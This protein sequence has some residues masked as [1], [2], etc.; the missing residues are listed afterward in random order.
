MFSKM[1]KIKKQSK[2]YFRQCKLCEA[3]DSAA[4]DEPSLML[5]PNCSCN[6]P[7]PS[8]IH[9][10][11]LVDHMTKTGLIRCECDQIYQGV[12]FTYQPKSISQYLATDRASVLKV[13]C[14]IS[15]ALLSFGFLARSIG[16]MVSQTCHQAKDDERK[17]PS[18][19][20]L[21]S[22][23]S[24]HQ[25]ITLPSVSIYLAWMEWNTFYSKYLEWAS[26]HFDVSFR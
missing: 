10:Q 5:Q 7:Y 18:S 6:E 13:F 12:D 3:G 21:D 19:L 24:F 25:Q 20:S 11:C 4:C 8:Y 23:S 17:A 1:P 16:R 15:T 14:T 9:R 26:K 2:K 22:M